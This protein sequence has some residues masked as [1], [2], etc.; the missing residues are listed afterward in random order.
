MKNKR[1][2]THRWV[3]RGF[4]EDLLSLR[5]QSA[6]AWQLYL[7]RVA[8]FRRG[9]GLGYA[10]PFISVLAHVVLLGSVMSLV[11]RE[12]IETFIPFFTI[13]FCLWQVIS[14]GVSESA[15]T[16]ERAAQYLSFPHVSGFIVHYVNT[17]ELLATVLLKILASLIIVLCV[18][19]RLL[20]HANY[21]A[22]LFGIGLIIV[23]MFAWSL[24]ISYF[25]DRFRILRGF[26][27]QIIF[28]VYLATPVM[29]SPDRLEGHRWV[30]DYNP[31]FHLIEV[32]RAPL[33]NG[34]VP[35]LSLF[36][37]AGLIMCGLLVSAALFERNRELVVYRWIA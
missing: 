4:V 14:I 24:P 35:A 5:R 15:N 26:L 25:F 3:D 34:T 12:P 31:V 7:A 18:N 29:W 9:S 8:E 37:T 22:L 32:G 20:Q 33:L 13:S 6:L 16:N 28:A 23:T 17:L 10:A 30:V 27:A 2:V 36:V 19:F 1:S 11:F 21:P